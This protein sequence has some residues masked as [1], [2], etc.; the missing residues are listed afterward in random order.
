MTIEGERNGQNSFTY[1]YNTV[2]VAPQ[3]KRM[4]PQMISAQ[5]H[6]GFPTSY[7]NIFR[8]W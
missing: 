2:V 8:R 1:V 4:L 6:K 7:N 5:R 3:V